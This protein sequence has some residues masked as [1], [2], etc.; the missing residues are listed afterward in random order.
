VERFLREARFLAK[1]R[2][3]NVVQIFELGR[4]EGRDFLTMEF[5]EGKPF[6]ATSDR[7]EAVARLAKVAR[8]LGHIH[9]RS[10]VHRD[11]KPS[12]ILVDPSGRPV[13]MD[14]GIAR[15][16]EAISTLSLA[17]TLVGTP[18]YM[19]P[20][21]FAGE[22]ADART[23]VY[24]LGV[25]LYEAMAGR[26]PFDGRTVVALAEQVRVGKAAPIPHVPRELDDV[27]RRAMAPD[28]E[29]RYPTADALAEDL[30]KLLAGRRAPRSAMPARLTWALGGATAGLLV[31]VGLFAFRPSPA[32][33]PPPPAPV[34]DTSAFVR[35]GRRLSLLGRFEE[36]H[37][38]FDRAGA[39]ALQPKGETVLTQHF[40]LHADRLLFPETTRGLAARL[41]ATQ[42]PA[43]DRLGSR[44]FAHVARGQWE[45]ARKEAPNDDFI[46]GAVE[47]FAEGKRM[48]WRRDP[49]AELTER[50]VWRVYATLHELRPVL[51]ARPNLPLPRRTSTHAGLLRVEALVH[52]ARED[53]GKALEALDRALAAAPDF[54]LARLAR[55][56]LLHETK[57]EERAA[58]E[59]KAARAQAERWGLALGE[60]D[61][62]LPER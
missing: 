38:A 43:F 55:V 31:V 36:A 3:P 17:G 24:A 10:I 39:D 7:R 26:R 14:F 28:P 47:F 4:H 22:T 20:E 44:F 21:Q 58:E 12:N 19:A 16:A 62:L 25:I 23:D 53:D 18:A 54:L 8:A 41:A 1:L 32:S 6:P 60:I 11:L 37:A 5:I 34:V 35:E 2:H 57:A 61:A 59:L 40:A 33:P 48:P 52:H 27:C 42:G 30:E 29:D 56:R 13:I 46:K 15:S 45:A 9:R 50:D 49:D 51:S